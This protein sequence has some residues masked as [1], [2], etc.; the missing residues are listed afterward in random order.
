M[1][2]TTKQVANQVICCVEA[3]KLLPGILNDFLDLFFEL[4]S[5]EGVLVTYFKPKASLLNEHGIVQLVVENWHSHNWNAV[6][7]C[8]LESKHTGVT[9]ECNCVG[10]S[11]KIKE[12]YISTLHLWSYESIEFSKYYWPRR[13]CCGIHLAA[14]TFSGTKGRYSS[15]NFI[16]T[17]CVKLPN[18]ER[19]FHLMFIGIFP[20]WKP[21]NPQL[22]TTTP[23][24]AVS[25]NDLKG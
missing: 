18:A 21:E 4:C 24:G 16:T 13:S 12:L 15:S 5:C 7:Q 11:W 14:I 23:P 8:L 1:W 25:M 6:I 19:R 3:S 20:G 9:H 17:R 2:Y 10:M 22:K